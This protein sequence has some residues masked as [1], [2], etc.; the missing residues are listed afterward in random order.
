VNLINGVDAGIALV[1][2]SHVSAVGF[3]GSVSAGRAL[4]QRANARTTPIP[5]YGELG[6]ANPLVVTVQAAK[7]RAVEIGKGFAGS[8]T[9]GAGQFCTKPGLLFVPTGT[10]GDELTAALTQALGALGTFIML[11]EGVARNFQ[12]G[13]KSMGS[14]GTVRALVDDVKDGQFRASARLFE[15]GAGDFLAPDAE[16]L[17]EECFGPAAVVVRYSSKEQLRKALVASERALTFSVFSG[18]DDGD[19]EWLLSLG[20]QRAGRV[21]VDGF[22][23]GVGVSW[24]MQHGGLWPSTTSSTA[25]SVGA[26]SIERWLRPVTFQSTSDKHLPLALREANPLDIP[27]RVDGV[28]ILRQG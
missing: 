22:P 1:E 19:E 8:M 13:A 4:W 7:E 17:R 27:R 16:A 24:S 6:A 26:A 11:S 5:F 9:L 3:T 12:S 28:Q 14:V 25:T 10:A 15:I 23:T 21:I 2:S 18:V 20:A